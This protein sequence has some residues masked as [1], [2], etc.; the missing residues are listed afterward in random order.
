MAK[1]RVFISSTFYDLRL[2]RLELDKF[3]VGL[4]YEPIRNEEGDIPY[5]SRESLQN[6]CYKEIYHADILISI[7]GSKFGNP[8]EGNRERSISNMELTTAINQ[9]KHVFIFI[10]KSVFIEYETFLL[11][12]EKENINYKY[13]DNTNIYK[14]IKEIKALPNNNNI[15]DFEEVDDIISYLREQFAGLMKNFFEQEQRSYETNIIKDINYTAQT[16]RDLVDYLQSSNQEKKEELNEI[17]KTSHP[18]IRELKELLHIQYKFYIEELNDLKNLLGAR[19]FTTV[20]EHNSSYVFSKYDRETGDTDKI[21]ISKDIFDENDRLK[22]YRP[23]EWDD[24]FI[25]LTREENDGLPF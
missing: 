21:T 6:Y 9:K 1:P 15:K 14:F 12:E 19:G 11:N 22:F 4:G 13:V 16:L 25:S 20:S 7:I 24:N 17:I 18:I 2:I 23:I 3:L 8:S 10:E 5:E